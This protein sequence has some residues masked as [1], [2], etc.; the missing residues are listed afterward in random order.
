MGWQK[1]YIKKYIEIWTWILLDKYDQILESDLI[2]F[3]FSG[4]FTQINIIH[5]ITSCAVIIM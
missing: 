1:V 3:F 4:I 2:Y 5:A